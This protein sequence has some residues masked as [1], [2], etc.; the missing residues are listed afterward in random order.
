M[1]FTKSPTFVTEVARKN[2]SPANSWAENTPSKTPLNQEWGPKISSWGTTNT[3]T[4]PS[5]QKK[6]IAQTPTV[7]SWTVKKTPTPSA[8]SW[9]TTP[10]STTPEAYLEALQKVDPDSP[11]IQ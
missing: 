1:P 11:P 6:P 9:S 7:A 10:R 2:S 3:G 5:I 4:T 8:T